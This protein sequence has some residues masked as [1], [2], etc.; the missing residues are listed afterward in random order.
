M[1]ARGLR[2]CARNYD[3]ESAHTR[4]R[5][6]EGAVT[7][8]DHREQQERDYGGIYTAR[9]IKASEFKTTIKLTCVSYLVLLRRHH[10]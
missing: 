3:K 10:P 5:S 4:V 2:A 6:N 9:H 1:L 8:L 7:E